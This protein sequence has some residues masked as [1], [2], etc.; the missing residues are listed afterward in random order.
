MKLKCN[1]CGKKFRPGN[2]PISGIPNGLGF[3]LKKW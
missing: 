2:N 1:V 3:T